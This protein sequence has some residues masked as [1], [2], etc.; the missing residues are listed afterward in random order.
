VPGELL[1]LNLVAVLFLVLLIGPKSVVTRDEVRVTLVALVV[2]S[3][4]GLFLAASYHAQVKVN[5]GGDSEDLE[6]SYAKRRT[7]FKWGLLTAAVVA[8]AL[9][10][11]WMWPTLQLVF[12]Y[13]TPAVLQYILISGLIG[14]F[15]QRL[16]GAFPTYHDHAKPF[17]M[18]AGICVC[19]PLAYIDVLAFAYGVFPLIPVSRGGANYIEAE[20]VQLQPAASPPQGAP[21]P[22]PSQPV[23]LLMETESAVFVAL[24]ETED[25][26]KRWLDARETPKVQIVHRSA[27]N[28][29]TCLP[30]KTSP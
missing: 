22:P 7:A 28:G 3:T 25:A 23:W 19:V 14:L 18:M 10:I 9:I 26:P 24:D 6:S 2:L 8:D 20:R 16:I 27:I 13:R 11:F 17:F 15:I 21:K 1:L 29:W 12:R 30:R 4:L 5:K